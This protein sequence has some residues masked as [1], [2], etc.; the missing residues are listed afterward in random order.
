MSAMLWGLVLVVLAWLVQFFA[1]LKNKK[2]IQPTFLVLYSLGT[3]LLVVEE[4]GGGLQLEGLL[5][6]AVL[7][8]VLLVWFKSK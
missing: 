7:F 3:L 1:A 8:L 5:Y 6:V 4:F 2:H